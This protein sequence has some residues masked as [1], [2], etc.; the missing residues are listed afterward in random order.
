[1]HQRHD[2]AESPETDADR[3]DPLPLAPARTGALLAGAALILYTAWFYRD[4]LFQQRVYVFRDTYTFLLAIDHVAR[5]L[6]AWNWPPLW[7]PFQIL[8]KPFA[9]DPLAAVYYP[10]NW[11]LRSLPEPLG[12]NASIALHHMGA[13]A[14]AYLLLR[15]WRLSVLAAALGGLLFGFGGPLVSVDNMINGLQSGTWIPWTI[16]AFEIWQE[17]RGFAALAATGFAIGTTLL[18][19]MPEY[20]LFANVL[21]VAL[22]YDHH[23]RGTGPGLVRSLVALAGAN[24]LAAG[25]YAVQLVPFAE[26][27]AHSS[28][29]GGLSLGGVAQYSLRPLGLLAF[30]L[31]RHFVDAGGAF[32]ET[33]ALWEGNLSHAPWALTLYLG[34][35][36]VLLVPAAKLLSRF[37]RRWWAGIGVVF[38]A[39]ALGKHLPG[40]LWTLE[41]VSPLR[42]VRYPEKF[43]LVAHA[44]LCVG[45]AAGLES[46]LRQPRRFRAVAAAAVGLAVLAAGGGLVPVSTT[47]AIALLR[48]DLLLLALLLAIISSLALVGARSARAARL[49]ALALIALAATDLYR[50]NGRLLPT[51][52][53][54]D[55]MRVPATLQAMQRGDDPLRIYSDGVGRPALPAF[56]E[57][58]IEEKN[59][60]LTEDANFYLVANFNAPAPV[61]LAD[62][63]ILEELVE[64]APRAR[65][66]AIF[67]AFNTAYVTS[68]KELHYP[69]L[70]LVQQPRNVL[71]AYLYR[72]EKLTPRAFVPRQLQ[73]VSGTKQA[74]DYLRD[75][76]ELS[77]RA[78][79][80]V[81]SIPADLPA[82]MTGQ[83][84]ITTYRPEEV[85]LSAHMETAGLVVLSDTYYPGWQAYVDG[86]RAP[87]VRA[88]YFVRGVYVRAGDRHIVF[89]YR[90]LSHRVGALI[91]FL[92]AG[93]VLLAMI[94]RM[95]RR[96]G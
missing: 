61:N 85:E 68:P 52:S 48:R 12:F 54:A 62:H 46:A 38:L 88:N 50:V 2:S 84:E 73:P 60:L 33:A 59:L 9:A 89:R 77:L 10:P 78:A 51:V 3:R 28:R 5:A 36:L 16:L 69:G 39:L 27:L 63:E 23:R 76:G 40:Y 56:P 58:F 41:H 53:W 8:G 94:W 87:I 57:S 92:T 31:P 18:G 37:Q 6:A 90:P 47:L 80:D 35:T 67:A 70:T 15:H 83:V 93:A 42:S 19:A 44:L 14:G 4:L 72:V 1:M 26:Y 95:I 64:R 65:A 55:A 74:I 45:V 24:L 71:E 82:E 21:L 20:F 86:A 34:P 66:A 11:L 81:A 29:A 43:L 13:A 91:S 17:R 25:L 96:R 75:G 49:A 22:A 79:V 7:S 32:H 30:L